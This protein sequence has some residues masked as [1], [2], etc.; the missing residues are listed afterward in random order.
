[1]LR[2]LEHIS[3]EERLGELGLFSL[4]R[5]RAWGTPHSSL[6]VLKGGF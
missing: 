5:R 2:G 4:E 1:M 3:C 6:S